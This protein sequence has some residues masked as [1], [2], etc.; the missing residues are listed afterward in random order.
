MWGTLANTKKA[1]ARKLNLEKNDK[2]LRIFAIMSNDTI[3]VACN[4]ILIA[5]YTIIIAVNTI[6]KAVNT[7]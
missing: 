6:K 4:K 3:I 5:V 2:T 1:T 7:N